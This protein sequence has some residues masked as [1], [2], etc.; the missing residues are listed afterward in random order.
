MKIW[1]KCLSIVAVM[2]MSTRV[3]AQVPGGAG[4]AGGATTGGAVSAAPAVAPA[5]APAAG[6]GTIWNFFGINKAGLKECKIKFCKSQIGILLGNTMKPMG[7]MSGGLLP[8]CC[9]KVLN[10]DALNKAAKE[11]PEAAKGDAQAAAA[12]IAKDEAEAKERRAAVRYLGTVDCH[13]WGDV[14]EPALIAALR[15]DRNECVRWEAAMALGNG[16]CCTKKTIAALTISVY[17]VEKE[18]L[19]VAGTFSDGAPVETSERVKGA[20]LG[21]LQH[22]LSCYTENVVP[23]PEKP[24]RGPEKT[25][26]PVAQGPVA[27]GAVTFQPA[28]YTKPVQARTMSQVV[29]DARQVTT[30]PTTVNV[31]LPQEQRIK[32]EGSSRTLSGV[33]SRAFGPNPPAPGEPPTETAVIPSA[34]PPRYSGLLPWLTR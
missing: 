30:T 23:G 4:A 22:C 21:A 3:W 13:Y 31:P 33:F 1:T 24:E 15:T 7:A 9:P 18:G 6:G 25:D 20:A 28:V 34:P 8:S 16:C 32:G 5:A 11:G 14:A 29:Q 2:G 17:G 26:K 12:K 19:T 10:E 27:Q